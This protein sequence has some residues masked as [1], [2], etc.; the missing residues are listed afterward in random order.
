[1]ITLPRGPRV[2]LFAL[3]AALV[4]AFAATHF[5]VGRY[6]DERQNLAV[7]W[8]AQGVRDLARHPAAAVADYETA[9]A[10]ADDADDRFSLAQALTRANR[11]A[12]ARAQLLTLWAEEPGSGRVNLEL[13]RLAAKAN[14]EADAIRYYHAAIDGAWESGATT[15]RRTARLELATF[16]LARGQNIRAQAELIAMIDDLPPDPALLTDVGQLLVSAGADARAMTLFQRA[17]TVGPGYAAAARQAAAVAF[18]AGNYQLTR[19]YLT[20][21]SAREPLDAAGQDE[22]AVATQ[23]LAVDPWAPRLSARVRAQ[24]TLACIAIAQRRLDRCQPQSDA[25]AD[26]ATAAELRTDIEAWGKRREREFVRDPDLI[27][28]AMSTVFRIEALRTPSCGQPH[29]DD[30]ALQLLAAERRAATR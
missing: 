26:D 1:M 13:G 21:A 7:E 2:T 23:I 8:R 18:R 22:L 16:L 12:E 29:A 3:V 20:T 25:G 28:D 30:R 24:R 5:V 4:P 10:Y 6:K 14:D 15:A 17:M 11:F 9:L 27:D 19:E